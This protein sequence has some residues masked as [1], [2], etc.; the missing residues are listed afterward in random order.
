MSAYISLP[1][2][3]A[4]TGQRLRLEAGRCRS[5]AALVYPQRPQ[6]P[7]CGDDAFDTAPLSGTGT[8]YTYTVIA[9][10]GAPAE[11]D[12]QQTMTGPLT[13]GVVALTEGPH[14]IAQIAD[15][16]PETLEIGMPLR[17][18]VRRLFDQEGVVRY[19]TKFV[20]AA[21]A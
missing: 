3:G 7:G 5:C 21:D 2:F 1:M 15:A 10:G 9:G 11:F 13:V 14:V 6:C 4:G 17:A 16:D 20:P 8:L 18:V 12:D 19:G